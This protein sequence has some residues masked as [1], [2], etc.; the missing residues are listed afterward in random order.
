MCSGFGKELT[1]M[2]DSRCDKCSNLEWRLERGMPFAKI[3][4]VAF[5]K[6]WIFISKDAIVSA[7]QKADVFFCGV[8]DV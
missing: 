6:A 8:N 5:G 3:E 2:R 4:D 7:E 1:D